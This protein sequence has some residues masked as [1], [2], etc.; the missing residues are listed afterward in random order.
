ME[1]CLRLVEI[2]KQQACS[3]FAFRRSPIGKR[4][5][6]CASQ[7]VSIVWTSARGSGVRP[8]CDEAV[9]KL[10]SLTTARMVSMKGF[11]VG[12]ST[13]AKYCTRTHSSR[14]WMAQTMEKA[15]LSIWSLPRCMT[16]IAVY[17]GVNISAWK[18]AQYSCLKA[19]GS[20]CIH[21]GY[22][23]TNE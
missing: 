10:T 5:Q 4:V 11:L 13:R 22:C 9:W 23:S 6:F 8:S 14:T 2:C 12:C 21:A 18:G 15:L 19:C 3:V 1:Y 17:I 7:P 20:C 16:R